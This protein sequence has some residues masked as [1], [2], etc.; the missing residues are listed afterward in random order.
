L[1]AAVLT[2]VLSG[3]ASAQAQRAMTLDDMFAVKRVSDPQISPDGKTIAYTITTVDK[4]ANNSHNEI[5]LA[6]AGGGAPIQLTNNPK[7]D[8]H[9]RWSPD[10]KWIA[11]ESNRSGSYQIYITDPDGNNLKQL[12]SISTEA[13][14]AVWSPDGKNLAFVSTVYPEFSDKAF[15]ESDALNKKKLDSVE[16]SKVK[17]R[18]I[19]RMFYRHWDSWVEDKRQHV[20]VVSVD[21]GDPKD[22]TPG[23]RDGA[24]TSETFS[25]GDD[26]DFSPDGAELAYTATPSPVH[27]ESWSTNYDI[28]TVNL[29][30]GARKLITPNKAADGYPR[31]SPD[32][33]YIAYR[34]QSKAGYESDRWQLMLYDRAAGTTRS[35]TPHFDSW[36][37][38]QV[39]SP[40]S[41]TLYFDAEDKATS[42]LWKV[43]ITGDS[44]KKVIS[45]GS[46][47]GVGISGDGK[48]LVFT[49]SSLVRPNEVYTANVNGGSTTRVTATNDSLFAQ[50]GYMQPES[51][52]Y[53]GAAGAKVQ[54]WI[55]KPPMFD[56][57]K[58]YPFILWVHGGPQGAYLDSWSYRWCPEVWAA[59]GYVLALPNP[60]GSTGFGQKF[61]EQISRD[62]GGKVYTDV[63]NGVA[64][65]EKQPYID[66]AR[67]AA[68][69]ASYGGYFM[70]WLEGHT[71]IFKTIVT[72][73]GV[74]DFASMYGSTEELWFEEYEHG[75]PWETKDFDKFSPNKFVK[76][77]VTPMLIIHSEN[78]FRI[79][80]T[81]GLELFTA[82]QRKGIAS[83]MIDFP[84]EGH[85]VLKPGDSQYWHQ[86]IFDWLASYLKK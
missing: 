79:S 67:M 21:G 39:W 35:L 66:T 3:I 69:G 46:N 1:I 50:I 84:S 12:T 10:G 78:D 76:N 77:F 60:R 75:I 5:W 24:P 4:D 25:A 55:I 86:T 57:K 62:W 27:D 6:P 59:Q 47:G 42:P 31:Y 70:D 72:H 58:K 29:A 73:D 48:T 20:F 37:G 11:F 2:A 28:Y 30:T 71:K 85:W 43:S 45:G 9:P 64:Y 44:V 41:K 17:V 26:Y 40:D 19:D 63:M 61:T 16:T 33:K 53:M 52:T 14:G 49:R 8:R 32:G 65:M 34:A 18:V 74:Y 38:A 56:P 51:V 7:Q 54:M 83:K 13:T 80:Y 81:Q 23:D 36:V 22:M 15:A 82:L 68:A